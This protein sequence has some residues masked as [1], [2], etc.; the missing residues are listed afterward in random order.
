MKF[1]NYNTLVAE[2]IR[3]LKDR[4]QKRIDDSKLPYYANMDE[5]TVFDYIDRKKA[6]EDVYWGPIISAYNA[7]NLDQDMFNILYARLLHAIDIFDTR[8][9]YEQEYQ[10]MWKNDKLTPTERRER[11]IE[12]ETILG[13]R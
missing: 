10:N 1:N 6:I 4:R 8:Y 11:T 2:R 12:L 13:R 3:Q 7:G 5:S 9:R